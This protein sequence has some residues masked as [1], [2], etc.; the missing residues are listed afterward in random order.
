[1]GCA[2]RT[3]LTMLIAA[4]AQT[5]AAAADIHGLAGFV[6][7]AYLAMNIAA[8]CARTDPHFLSDTSGPRGTPLHYAQ[9]VKDEAIA[10]LPQADAIAVLKLA[11]DD[12]RR[13]ARAMLYERARPG[14][15][16]GTARAIKE[17]C[18]TEAKRIVLGFLGNHDAHSA[19]EEFLEQ[20][21]R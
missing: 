2:H 7:P 20:A 21:K 11:A 19:S 18:D 3:L 6:R 12:A 9:H 1:M 16:I 10:G 5:Q 17:W 13:A 14:D 15:D 8:M 4:A